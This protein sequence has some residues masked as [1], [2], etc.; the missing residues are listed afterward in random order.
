MGLT[1]RYLALEQD[2]DLVQ[3]W[4]RAI[5]PAPRE[6]SKPRGVL[7]YF[8]SLGAL[9]GDPLDVDRSPLVS[10]FAPRRRRGVLHTAGEVHFLPTPLRQQFP[11]LHR[12]SRRFSSWLSSFPCVFEG[13]SRGDWDYY[14][15]GSLK[16]RDGKIFALPSAFAALQR[17]QYFVADD[18]ND[19]VIDKL[20]RSLRLR[21][22]AGIT[23]LG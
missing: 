21:G 2:Q 22:V 23:E 17:G 11:V 6:I 10:L 8:D 5:Q 3:D 15:E 20:C 14:L 9:V 4:F 18:D 12:L 16:N 1:F 19:F 7:L 13:S